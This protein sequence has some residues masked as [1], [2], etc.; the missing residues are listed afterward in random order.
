MLMVRNIGA[1][2]MFACEKMKIKVAEAFISSVL[3]IIG[4]EEEDLSRKKVF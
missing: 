4:F 2:S 3:K 1:I